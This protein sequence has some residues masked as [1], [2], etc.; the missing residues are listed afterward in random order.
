MQILQLTQGNAEELGTTRAVLHSGI[1]IPLIIVHIQQAG[2]YEKFR[3]R[4]SGLSLSHKAQEGLL[5]YLFKASSS[6]KKRYSNTNFQDV[7]PG[8]EALPQSLVLCEKVHNDVT[9]STHLV[10]RPGNVQ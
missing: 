3:G 2:L 8:E 9:R 4:N 1:A 6:Y 5:Q 7:L 10:K